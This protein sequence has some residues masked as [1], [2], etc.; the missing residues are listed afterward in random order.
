L[1][2]EPIR[3]SI[4]I[5]G[6]GGRLISRTL[7]GHQVIVPLRELADGLPPHTLAKIELIN[8]A[9]D[10]TGRP[11]GLVGLLIQSTSGTGGG[12][13]IA[14]RLWRTWCHP[15]FADSL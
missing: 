9:V 14:T 8:S 5:T 15:L 7:T 3:A 12:T 6:N 13:G 4:L 11:I 2:D 1:S 10:E